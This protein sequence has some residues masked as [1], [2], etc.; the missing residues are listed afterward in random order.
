MSIKEV[1]VAIR[2][3]QMN[4]SLVDVPGWC[5]YAAEKMEQVAIEADKTAPQTI[6]E[7]LVY[8]DA[9]VAQEEIHYALRVSSPEG[10]IVYNLNQAGMFPK[11]VGDFESAPGLISK[12]KVTEK[13]L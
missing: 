13:V 2:K 4:D 9:S 6:K 7:I 10:T 12:M 3:L 8:P 11:Y 5:R 1:D